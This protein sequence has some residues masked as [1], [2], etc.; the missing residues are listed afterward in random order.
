MKGANVIDR[1]FKVYAVRNESE[2]AVFSGTEKE[3]WNYCRS[4]NWKWIAPHWV[5]E[6]TL[7]PV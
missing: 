2:L 4:H 5:L 3:C 7:Y 6:V 1:M